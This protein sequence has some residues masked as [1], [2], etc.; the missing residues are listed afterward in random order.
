MCIRDRVQELFLSG[1]VLHV[2]D[3]AVVTVAG[4][5]HLDGGTLSFDTTVG[6]LDVLDVNG[7]LRQTGTAIGSTS[8]QSLVRV[9]GDWTAETPFVLS[10]G[11][12][13]LDGGPATVG[14]A[15]PRFGRLSLDAGVKTIASETRI[16]EALRSQGGSTAGPEWLVI[17]GAVEPVVSSANLLHRVRVAA[18]TVPFATSLVGELELTGGQ[19]HLN[20]AATL[21]V[22][23][24]VRLLG[25]VL[26]FDSTVGNLDVLDVGGALTQTAATAGTTT[27]QSR[28][29]CAGD[30]TSN[31]SFA[32]AAGLVELDGPGT[33][34]LGGASPTFPALRLRNGAREVSAETTLTAASADVVAGATLRVAGETL[35]LAG[36]SL[37]VH[38]TLD[39]EPGARLGADPASSVL[40]HAGGRLELVG[41]LGAPAVLEGEPLGLDCTV[42]GVLAARHF[43]V[44]APAAGGFRLGATA[45]LAPAPDDLRGGLFTLPDPAP[46][47]TLLDLA[48]G[49]SPTLQFVGFEDPLGLG[50]FNVRRAGGSAVAFQNYGGA[51]GGGAFEDDPS[52]VIDWL[53]AAATELAFFD[54]QSGPEQVSLA[55][56]TLSEV[57]TA[58]FRVEAAPGPLGPFAPVTDL[59]ATGPGAYAF[60]HAPLAPDVPVYYRLA[61]LLT[62]GFQRELAL[63][64][65]LPYSAATPPNVRRVGPSGEF[66]TIQAAID[67]ATHPLTVIAVE[68]GAYS[69]FTIDTP[70]VLALRVVSE[71][72]GPV[73]VDATQQPIEITGLAA[74]QLAELVGL[75][76]QGGPSAAAIDVHDNAGTVLLDTVS[77]SSGGG[78]PALDVDASLTVA[79][80]RCA[81]T[82]FGQ[83]GLRAAGATRLYAGRGSLDALELGPGA[84][85]QLAQLVPLSTAVDPA[86]TLVEHAGVQPDLQFDSFQPLG[87]PFDAALDTAPG[88]L[89]QLGV[90]PGVLPLDLGDPDFWQ[91]L[92]LLDFANYA[93]LATGTSDPQT[94]EA[95]IPLELP[96][97]AVFLGLAFPVQA[98]TVAVTPT[99]SVR[100]SNART[101]I[102]MP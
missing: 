32:M 5:A 87:Q 50:T 74:G 94:G 1:G 86:A 76:V 58:T 37:D 60:V 15:A 21:T 34:S 67:A 92:L 59:A 29:Y 53:P 64:D 3:A 83:P 55:W 27:V 52:D 99:V 65:A 54:A 66:A 56:A 46:G 2:A 91:M 4:D 9:A 93:V 45:S 71:G 78:G 57:G 75:D 30:W 80:Q 51:F 7:A 63:A 36:T 12:V 17:E 14:G 88:S 69:A 31:A 35:H 102:G 85:A 100:F 19:L 73:T 16:E 79:V 8:P 18:G 33:T 20:D 25:G 41:E 96:A 22:Q 70:G 10:Q 28:I 11:W 68:P 23:G 47:S 97:Q 13:R 101:L 61:E 82:G 72:G 95:L 81:L 44:R 90:A 24:D 98:W 48:L 26:S 43:E 49:G 42:N 39:V 38:G 84:T 77:S 40:V 62:D 6:N 89:Y